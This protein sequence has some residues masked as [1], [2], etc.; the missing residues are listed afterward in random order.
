MFFFRMLVRFLSDY[1]YIIA[2]VFLVVLFWVQ[3]PHKLTFFL[4]ALT[5]LIIAILLAHLNRWTHLYPAHLYFPSGHITFCFG[6]SLS[7]GMLRRWT[8]VI[9]LPLLVV[10]GRGL[11]MV[12][13][14]SLADVL[15]A[16]PLVLVVYGIVHWL[17]RLPPDV[18]SPRHGN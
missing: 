10:M 2:V 11:I 13:A 4:R 1:P 12:Q 5:A 14:H 18:T 9:T 6:V 7:L 17:W 16:I 3:K 15:G 8:L